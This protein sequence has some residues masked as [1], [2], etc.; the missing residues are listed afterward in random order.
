MP[1]FTPYYMVASGHLSSI[2][3]RGKN[4]THLEINGRLGKL[5]SVSTV[6]VDSISVSLPFDHT[7]LVQVVCFHSQEPQTH[8]SAHQG[9]WRSAQSCA[10]HSRS[11][12][13][14]LLAGC[15]SRSCHSCPQGSSLQA[16]SST[17]L[18][19]RWGADLGHLEVQV[20]T[21]AVVQVQAV[22]FLEVGRA[23]ND[24]LQDNT[25]F[26]GNHWIPISASG[27]SGSPSA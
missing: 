19:P 12:P 26:S 3:V 21:P 13:A 11:P 24:C 14:A 9:R 22:C 20:L 8:S 27:G 18:L 10:D 6:N 2:Q 23:C 7:Q 16:L 4:M 25:P 17:S 5:P 1:H 15:I